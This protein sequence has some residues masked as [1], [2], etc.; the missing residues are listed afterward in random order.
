MGHNFCALFEYLLCVVFLVYIEIA[1][2][3]DL[4]Q[5][6]VIIWKSDKKYLQKNTEKKVK[7]TQTPLDFSERFW[8]K[9][10]L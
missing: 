2:I 7:I 8:G 9:K 10:L 1:S 5:H 6:H 4:D 3:F